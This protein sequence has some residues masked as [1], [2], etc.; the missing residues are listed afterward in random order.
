MTRELEAI[1][2]EGVFRPL[3]PLALANHQR[4]LL[5]VRDL[6]NDG[7][8]GS[9]DH[10]REE[11]EWLRAHGFE[12]AGKWVALQGNELICSGSGAKEV[13]DEARAKGIAQPLVVRLP[14]EPDRLSAGW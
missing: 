1:Y 6:P 8:L 13:R 11:M 10:R 3:E 5:T 4:V 2:D 14:E 12:Y 9:N 7:A